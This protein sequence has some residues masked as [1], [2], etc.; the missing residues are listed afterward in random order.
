MLKQVL[1][2]FFWFF[3]W[4]FQGGLPGEIKRCVMV[5]APH[6]SNWD[7]VIA[8][9]AFYRMNVPVRFVIKREWLHKFW[10]GG[11]L[12]ESGA[13]G[14]N[15]EKSMNKVDALAALLAGEEDIIMLIPPEGTRNRVPKWKTGFYYAAL[16][17]RVPIV[18]SYL[19]YGKRIA[20]IGPWFMPTGDFQADM[21]LLKSYY[22]DIKG[23]YPE[24]FCLDIY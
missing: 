8:R 13:V 3:G 19:D 23:R 6:T 17:A 2:F 12:R 21:E 15:R 22:K 18:L 20:E 16:K 10:V 5:A 24:N 14:V 7:F 11:L 1:L 4:K 9:A